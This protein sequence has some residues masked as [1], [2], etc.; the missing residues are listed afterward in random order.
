MK[1]S[2]GGYVT[3]VAENLMI[4]FG[5]RT[6]VALA[7]DAPFRE[8]LVRFW[9]NHLVVPAIKQQSSVL[10]GAYER[11]VIRPHVTG[12]FADMLMASA[13]NPGMLVFLDNYQ[14]IGPNSRYGRGKDKGINENLAREILELHTMGVEGGYSQADVIALSKAL[15]GWSTWPVFEEVPYLLPGRRGRP[16]GAF[17]FYRGWHEPGDFEL[18]GKVYDQ[19]GAAQGEAMLNDLARRPET[20]RFLAFKL[21]QHFVDDAPS[22]TLVNRLAD[23]YLESDTDLGEMTR[24]LIE[25]EEAWREESS[26]LKQ[27]EDY[28]ISCLRAL[29]IRLG[30]EGRVPPMPLYDFEDY[31]PRK[32]FWAWLA[33]DKFNF[34]EDKTA[35]PWTEPHQAAGYQIAAL[36]RDIKAMGQPPMNAPGPQGWY[37]TWEAWS[38]SDSLVKRI[39]WALGAAITYQDRAP[40]ARAFL[41]ET[42]GARAP[43][44][45]TTSVSRAATLDQGLGLILASPAF[46]RR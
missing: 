38:G 13:K 24:A 22:E 11:E 16:N 46:Q 6:N 43:E 45:L 31:V 37:D 41:T 9:S 4:E 26:K 7:T 23:V 21:A 44:S 30:V 36:Y 34:L 8:R 17:I 33:D 10:A 14:S 42:L 29:G 27:P 3:W 25:S 12:K 1:R 18:L 19:R 15:T 28:A 35:A 2:L 20:A 40:D 5:A 39:E 32:S